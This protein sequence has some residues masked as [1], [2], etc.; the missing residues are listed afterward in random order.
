MT[1]ALEQ[2]A[3]ARSPVRVDVLAA[4]SRSWRFDVRAIERTLRTLGIHDPVVLQTTRGRT[5]S[6]RALWRT[7]RQGREHVVRVDANANPSLASR[8][9]WHELAHVSQAEDWS[10]PREW[11]EAYDAA[12]GSRGRGY[13]TNPYEL[14]ANRWEANAEHDPLVL[15]A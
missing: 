1:V 3:A 6:G 13:R 14:E 7:T 5:A 8:I 11:D 10:S 12:G 4:V 9:L 15:D 2:L